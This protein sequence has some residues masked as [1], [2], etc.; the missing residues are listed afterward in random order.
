MPGA[1]RNSYNNKPLKVQSWV[2]ELSELIGKG[3]EILK[4]TGDALGNGSVI[5]ERMA[6]AKLVAKTLKDNLLE[7]EMSQ[8]NA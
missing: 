1:E 5:A 8:S 4:T 6:K 2:T 3:N 7:I